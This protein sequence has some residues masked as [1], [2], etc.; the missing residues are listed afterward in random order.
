ML[1][2]IHVSC[3]E[4]RCDESCLIYHFISHIR[5]C[6]IW[7]KVRSKLIYNSIFFF[8]TVLSANNT[9]KHNLIIINK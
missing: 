3:I 2:L 7:M 6:L 4:E 5:F 8:N 1:D 9:L